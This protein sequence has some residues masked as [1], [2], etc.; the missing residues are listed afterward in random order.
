MTGAISLARAFCIDDAVINAF[1]TAGA[2]GSPLQRGVGPHRADVAVLFARAGCPAWRCTTGSGTRAP[3]TAHGRWW[4]TRRAALGAD[5][6]SLR[7][8]A[9]DWRNLARLA[10]AIPREW[11]G[12]VGTPG[13]Q[14]AVAGAEPKYG[15]GERLIRVWLQ[16]MER[17]HDDLP[18]ASENDWW[19]YRSASRA[20]GQRRRFAPFG[21]PRR[22][23]SRWRLRRTRT[24]PAAVGWAGMDAMRPD[25]VIGQWWPTRPLSLELMPS[26][27]K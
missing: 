18:R 5:C 16:V 17:T 7:T 1:S 11:G 6:D 9:P 8:R 24:A 13:R 27:G 12:G 26:S 21:D 10:V 22:A 15:D 4:R 19:A 23:C 2:V 25:F 14:H 3:M 20:R